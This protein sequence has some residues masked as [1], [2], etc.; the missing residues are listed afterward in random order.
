MTR[1]RGRL[2][3]RASEFG[4]LARAALVASR[5]DASVESMD[6]VLGLVRVG[7]RLQHDLERTVHRPQGMTWAAYRVLF[8]L[9]AAGPLAPNDLARLSSVTP[10]SMSAVLNTLEKYG[11]VTRARSDVDARMTIVTM[12]DHGGDTLERL[13]GLNNRREEQ[14]AAILTERERVTLIRLLDKLLAAHLPPF[15][16]DEEQG[17]GSTPQ[18]VK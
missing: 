3:P 8:T 10:A 11:M 13:L 4:E 6:V 1:K 5:P 14:W 15:D 17:A 16:P 9:G 7:N 12:T 18:S 2:A